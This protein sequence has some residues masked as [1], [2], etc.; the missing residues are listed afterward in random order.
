MVSNSSDLLT[1]TMMLS[2][3]SAMFGLF[4]YPAQGIYKSL[5]SFGKDNIQDQIRTEKL[6]S[7][8]REK[9]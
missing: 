2:E 3:D 8:Q 5:K 4:A 1:M 9:S 7:F 6:A